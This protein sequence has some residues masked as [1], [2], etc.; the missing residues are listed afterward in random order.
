MSW[1]KLLR[2]EQTLA[3][4]SALPAEVRRQIPSGAS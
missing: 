2:A 4:D 1:E 3:E